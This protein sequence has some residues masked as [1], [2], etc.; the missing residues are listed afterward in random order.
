[1]GARGVS[2]A[3][4]VYVGPVEG[5]R[6]PLHE[7]CADGIASRRREGHRWPAPATGL[8]HFDAS[9]AGAQIG[10]TA[11]EHLGALH[12]GCGTTLIEP[13]G[14]AWGL[15]GGAVEI[16]KRALAAS[17]RRVTGLTH[18]WAQSCTA[19]NW[20]G[21]R[22][23]SDQRSPFIVPVIEGGAR[24]RRAAMPQGA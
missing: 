4:R 12:P 17:S 24:H 2:A 13:S 7:R 6:V 3:R 16:R 19:R 1:M 5:E 10:I 15:G 9:A 22:K 11:L 21:S 20:G 8:C 23:I 18:G 14:A